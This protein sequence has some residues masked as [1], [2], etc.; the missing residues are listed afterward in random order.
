MSTSI[1]SCHSQL[2]EHCGQIDPIKVKTKERKQTLKL[3]I[4]PAALARITTKNKL[5]KKLT[6]TKSI[7]TQLQF[8]ENKE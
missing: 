6:K 5:Y 7:E 8:K 2:D 1:C 4:T 3:W